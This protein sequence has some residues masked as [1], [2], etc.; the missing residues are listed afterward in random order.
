MV[1]STV[2]TSDQQTKPNAQI[3]QPSAAQPNG[4]FV[5]QRRAHLVAHAAAA[6]CT[7]QIFADIVF[8]DELVLVVVFLGQQ[9]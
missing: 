5:V 1:D 8:H 6:Q 9:I 7:Y 4:H 3:D 2:C